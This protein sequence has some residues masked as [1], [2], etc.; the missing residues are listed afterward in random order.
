MQPSIQ[1]LRSILESA[2][3]S[4]GQV[5]AAEVLSNL[6]RTAIPASAECARQALAPVQGANSSSVPDWRDLAP[7]QGANGSSVPEDLLWTAG[8]DFQIDQ[9]EGAGLSEEQIRR[10]SLE[11]D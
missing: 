8:E 9:E 6:I 10:M 3:N 4:P 11:D 5:D 7:V 2:A 1:A